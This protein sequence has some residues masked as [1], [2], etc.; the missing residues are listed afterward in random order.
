MR[1]TRASYVRLWFSLSC[2]K[3][4]PWN[5]NFLS[6]FD[7]FGSYEWM[8]EWANEWANHSLANRARRKPSS[9]DLN[10]FDPLLTIN[11]RLVPLSDAA[12]GTH[13]HT[14]TGCW[15]H[16]CCCCCCRRRRRRPNQS[17]RIACILTIVSCCCCRNWHN[18]KECRDNFANSANSSSSRQF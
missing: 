11:W 16:C 6:K 14:H 3:R 15:W 17:I 4:S 9:T 12:S 7:Q 8:N 13:T 5:D 2:L 1:S 18:A 10:R